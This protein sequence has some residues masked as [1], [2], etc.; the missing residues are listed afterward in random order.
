MRCPVRSK[1]QCHAFPAD[2]LF[3]DTAAPAVSNCR[4]EIIVPESHKKWDEFR[5]HAVASRIPHKASEIGRREFAASCVRCEHRCQLTTSRTAAVGWTN[6]CEF[7]IGSNLRGPSPATTPP[8]V[9]KNPSRQRPMQPT[10]EQE[11]A[12]PHRSTSPDAVFWHGHIFVNGWLFPRT[13]DREARN[14]IHREITGATHWIL[15][16]IST[17]WAHIA[18]VL[19]LRWKSLLPLK[20]GSF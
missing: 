18:N 20:I 15:N 1:V 10:A 14:G 16:P 4:S 2:T 19:C 5:T 6:R 7:A 17:Y 8:T 9:S 12:K 11:S 3:H 13:P